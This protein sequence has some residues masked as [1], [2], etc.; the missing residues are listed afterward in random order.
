MK[1]NEMTFNAAQGHAL[2][3]LEAARR[4]RA[5]LACERQDAAVEGT[6]GMPPDALSA[7][8]LSVTGC[9]AADRLIALLEEAAEIAGALAVLGGATW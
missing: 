4:A 8:A 1:P 9:V 6:D 3:A 5:P 2:N 7:V